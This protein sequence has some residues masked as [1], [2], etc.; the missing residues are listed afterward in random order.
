MNRIAATILGVE[1]IVVLLA[2]PVAVN[3]AD[4]STTAGWV[5][6]GIVALLCLVGAATV[7]RGAVGYVI[8]SAAQVGAIATGFVIPTMF[9]LG[10]IFALLWVVLLKIGPRV[11]REKAERERARRG[12]AAA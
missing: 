6:A 11:E 1:M 4:V 12:G 8:G 2:V 3:V 7:R 5:S 9:V 10:G